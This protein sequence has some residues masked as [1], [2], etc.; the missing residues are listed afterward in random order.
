MGW[1]FEKVWSQPPL[2][3]N[4]LEEHIISRP[5]ISESEDPVRQ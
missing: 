2:R 1:Y 5:G 4:G 3:G